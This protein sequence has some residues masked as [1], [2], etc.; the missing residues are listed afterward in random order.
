MTFNKPKN[1]NVIEYYQK[2]SGK[3]AKIYDSMQANN[4]HH[5]WL[6]WIPCHGGLALDIGSGSGRDAAW[7]ATKGFEVHAVEPV[8]AF[9]S[10][11][12]ARYGKGKVEWIDDKLPEL[13]EI[14]TRNYRYDFILVSAV[15][16]HLPEEHRKRS[17]RK[18]SQLLKSGGRMVIT[19]RH[20]P[21][22][23]ERPMYAVPQEELL[24]LGNQYALIK[25][26]SGMSNDKQSRPDITF[27]HTVFELPDDGT[28][29]LPILRHFIVNDAK[30]AT[31]KL[32]LLRVL[33]RIADSCRGAVL[34]RENNMVSIPFGLVGLY[35]VKIYKQLILD[36]ELL[37]RPNP[38]YDFVKDDFRALKGQSGQDLRLGSRL[39]GP[40]LRHVHRSIAEA[41]KTIK[42]MP[43]A[44]LF[45]P[46]GQ[47]GE[48][49]TKVFSCN[50]RSPVCRDRSVC[51]DLSYLA[52]F[53]NFYI[54]ESLWDTITHYAC[55]LEPSI[56]N[57]WSQQML[58]FHQRAGE[59][60]SMDLLLSALRWPQEVRNTRE[61]RSIF[62]KLKKSTPI[63]C[64]WT[65]TNLS[66]SKSYEVDH[67][68]PYANWS[69]NDLWNLLPSS[70]SANSSKSNLLPSA[71]LLDKSKDL[72][73][74]WWDK[75]YCHETLSEQ[76]FSEAKVSL[77]LVSQTLNVDNIY[78][79]VKQQRLHLKLDQQMK[80][81][82]GH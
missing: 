75:A 14:G 74:E 36:H 45:W 68:F 73:L 61:V 1:M 64:V 42:N 24:H 39:S 21:C 22:E 33:I 79:A 2:N 76:F 49:K 52:K 69:N 48:T 5:E 34:T 27:S 18:L 9:R 60:K 17:F 56:I 19:L 65:G 38:K 70:K 10:H 29:S 78:T 47:A 26:N 7:L 3:L 37:Q 55:W 71:E 32:G 41:C 15:W 63:Y 82:Q 28:G 67:C 16:M 8:A 43:V 23:E 12:E 58:C 13:K 81:W 80:E 53:G 30:E 4:V 57:V 31:Y 50:Y 35:W 54:P 6:N 40:R 25:L 46:G 20:G 62:D 44:H 77:P 72:I 59:K 11:A 66:R 51:L